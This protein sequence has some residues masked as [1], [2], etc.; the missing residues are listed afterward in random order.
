MCSRLPAGAPRMSLV[1]RRARC[2]ARPAPCPRALTPRTTNERIRGS[3]EALSLVVRLATAQLH[4]QSDGLHGERH[5]LARL[6]AFGGADRLEVEA[7]EEHREHHLSF[8]PR[9]VTPRGKAGG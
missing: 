4:P 3:A 9:G 1:Q 7:G 8:V 6:A 2:R 5:P